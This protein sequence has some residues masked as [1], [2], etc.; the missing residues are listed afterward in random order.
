MPGDTGYV[1]VRIADIVP[2]SP[3]LKIAVRINDNRTTFT[4]QTEC[5]SSN[6]VMIITNPALHLM[7]KKDATLNLPVTPI[8]DNGTYPNPVSVLYGEDIEY[9][10]TAVNANVNSGTEIIIQDTLPPYLDLVSASTPFTQVTVGSTP[11]RTMIEWKITG[12]TSMA[13]TSVTVTATPQSGSCASQ[14]MF[15]NRAWVTASDTLRLPTN[16]TYHQGASISIVT[17]S[18]GLGGNIYN[19]VPQAVD[20]K[21]SALEGII[22]VPEEGYRFTGWSHNEYVSLR[23]ENIPAEKDIM[24]YDTLMIYG[25]VELVANFETEKYPICYMMNGSINP[26]NNPPEYTIESG[27]ISLKAPEKAGDTFLGWTGSNGVEPQLNVNISKGSTGERIFFANFLHSGR[28]DDLLKDNS[29]KDRIWAAKDE[30]YIQTSKTGSTVRI[31]STEGILRK[32][33][34]ILSAGETRIKLQPG[35]YIVTLNNGTGKKIFIK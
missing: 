33:Q 1:T 25:N 6:N 2:Y 7:M 20:Y 22:V 26:V 11:P 34:T 12:L 29:N 8:T 13:T 24:Q 35:I 28:E 19:A 10:I 5:D 30:L 21:S 15:M 23:E 3:M 27:N 17:F 31:Y 16:Y 18:A 4:Y 9:K 14:P 32:L